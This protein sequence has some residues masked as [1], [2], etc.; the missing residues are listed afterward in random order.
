MSHAI[1]KTMV[2][3]ANQIFLFESGPAGKLYQNFGKKNKPIHQTWF[4]N[5]ETNNKALMILV[6]IPWRVRD[7]QSEHMQFIVTES[8]LCW[9]DLKLFVGKHCSW[10]RKGGRLN[11]HSKLIGRRA[12]P[13]QLTGTLALKRET[14]EDG[15]WRGGKDGQR[16]PN[17]CGGRPYYWQPMCAVTSVHYTY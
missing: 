2:W 7:K 6:F 3:P 4:R 8:V 14:R 5:I 1:E 15:D 17:A 9:W 11:L 13:T 12:E 16:T 10:L